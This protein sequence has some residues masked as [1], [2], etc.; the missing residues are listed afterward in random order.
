[1][2]RH[3]NTNESAAATAELAAAAAMTELVAAWR[4]KWALEKFR[5]CEE[6]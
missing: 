3:S 2:N 4:R 1:M 5:E 6:K